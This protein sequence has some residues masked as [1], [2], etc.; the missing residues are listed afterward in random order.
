MNPT[1][2]DRELIVA[3]VAGDRA[4]AA[5]FVERFFRFIVAVAGRYAKSSRSLAHSVSQN[6]IEQL[7]DDDFRALRMWSGQGDFASYLAS[8]VKSRALDYLR[9]PWA[10][11]VVVS[12]LPGGDGYDTGPF[13]LPDR[14]PD[15]HD[16]LLA[17]E[18]RHLLFAAMDRLGTR[19][20]E[21]L[22][23]RWIREESV[24]EIAE[25]LALNENAA[26]QALHRAL[27]HL[28][29]ELK[30]NALDR[31]GESLDA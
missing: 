30:E 20:R 16:V 31:F 23:R 2:T 10:R 6:V 3:V 1:V 25:A 29:A 7:W 5:L 18:R 13:G 9:A 15:A 12:G 8:I 28:R 21:I 17:E 4:A 22:V 24:S 11:R 14:G 27:R 19:D 26:H